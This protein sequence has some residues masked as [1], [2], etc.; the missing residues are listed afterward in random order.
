MSL[1]LYGPPG[2]GKTTL[3]HVISLAT[4]RQFVQLSALDAGVKEVRAVID[5]RQARAH[6]RRPAHR[7]VHRRGAPLLQDPAGLACCRAVEDRIVSLIAR[8]HREPVL[9]RRQPAAVAA[10]SCSPCSR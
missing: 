2:T 3:A 1:V 5:G 4:K 8:H 9:L 7:A 10:A 6:L